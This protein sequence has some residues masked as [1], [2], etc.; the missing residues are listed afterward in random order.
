MAQGNTA[1]E[2]GEDTGSDE[3]ISDDD[4]SEEEDGAQG[5]GCTQS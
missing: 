3:D 5:R 2:E 1:R 4:D